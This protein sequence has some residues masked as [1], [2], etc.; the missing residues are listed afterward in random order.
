MWMPLLEAGAFKGILEKLNTGKLFG[1]DQDEDV[2]A[3]LE[4]IKN[5]QFTFIPANFKYVKKYLRLNGVNNVDGILADLGYPPINLILQLV[6]FYPI[7]CRIGYEDGSTRSV[8]RQE[9][10]QHI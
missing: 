5:P 6:V 2:L 10:H 9:N 4:F 1:F 3:N 8:N 7:R